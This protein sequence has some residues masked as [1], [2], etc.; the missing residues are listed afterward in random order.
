MVAGE[1]LQTIAN[2]DGLTGLANRRMFDMTLPKEWRRAIRAEMPIAL[3]M[4]DVDF[5]KL[6]NDSYGHQCGD[7]VLRQIAECIGR[8][9]RRPADTAGRYGGEEFVALLPDTEMAGVVEVA[10]RICAAVA[11][12]DIPHRGS[13]IGRVTVSI[14]VAETRPALGESADPLVKEADEALYEA[15][16]AG[17]N[18]VCTNFKGNPP[19]LQWIPGSPTGASLPS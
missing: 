15:K 16:R 18:R 4:L 14:G 19:S 2:T 17:R 1:Q 12:L 7:Q 13:P 6:F 8:N 10:E 11:D 9:V 3:L 5:F